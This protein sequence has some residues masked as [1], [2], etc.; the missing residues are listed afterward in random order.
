[1]R[2]RGLR[3]HR[4]G[5]RRHA[6]ASSSSAAFPLDDVR[7]F[8]SA[9][10][11]GTAT[12]LGRR[13]GRGRGRRDGRLR[14]ARPRALSTGA[15]ASLELAPRL[16]AAGAIVIDNSS[17]W[18][19]DPDVPLVVPEVN[20]ARAGADPEGHRRQPELHDHGGD[21][22]AE[23]A[24]RRGRARA[25]WSSRPT[26]RSR[27]PGWPGVAELDEQLAKTVGRARRRSPSTAARVEFPGADGLRRA[28]RPQRRP[29]RR[30]ARRRRLGRDRRGAEV[31]Q[32]EP[33]DPRPPRPGRR[34]A[35]AC[36][37]PVFTGHGAVHHRRVRPR[38]SSPERAAELL[39]D[40]PG[41][42]ARR[43]ADAARG[44]RQRPVLVGRIRRDAD[45][46][47]RPRALRR[48]ATTCA[49]AR[50]STPSRSPRRSSTSIGARRVGSAP[51]AESGPSS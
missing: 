42:R 6:L 15:S 30:P 43:R 41:R 44:G 31:P 25:G 11:A 9:R 35:P 21:A 51:E 22:G 1:M 10:S 16:A 20:A 8:A 34:R 45:R 32:R 2:R 50:R 27:A 3:R 17:A 36:G 14:R 5:R 38:R 19:M 29:A 23:A 28:D 37:C 47:P 33:Q 40:A 7:F 49:R 48:R 46:R 26:R 4:A 39:A 12:A 13:R 24:P 18:R